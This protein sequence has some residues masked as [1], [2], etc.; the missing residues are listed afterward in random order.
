MEGSEPRATL[1]PFLSVAYIESYIVQSD[2]TAL[3]DPKSCPNIGVHLIYH[4]IELKTVY[5]LEPKDL[6]FYLNKWEAKWH[7]DGEK[8]INNPKI[9][10]ADVMESGRLLYWDTADN[11]ERK[12]KLTKGH[13]GES[14]LRLTLKS[15]FSHLGREPAKVGAN[16]IPRT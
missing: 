3:A 5:V 14:I 9:P 4:H 2:K 7:G 1:C 10:V 12:S 11:H 6:E 13:F 15:A 16:S 8:D